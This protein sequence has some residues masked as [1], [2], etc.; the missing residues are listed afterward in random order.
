MFLCPLIF[1]PSKWTLLL[2]VF[3]KNAPN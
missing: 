1:R 3:A 2:K